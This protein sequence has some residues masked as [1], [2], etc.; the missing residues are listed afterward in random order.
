MA[1]FLKE[2]AFRERTTVQAILETALDRYLAKEA[3]QERAAFAGLPPHEAE[4]LQET[5][6]A[7]HHGEPDLV[8]IIRRTVRTANRIAQAQGRVKKSR[9]SA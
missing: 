3:P 2:K 4:F 8:E 9:R 6:D 7:L 1:D 5:L